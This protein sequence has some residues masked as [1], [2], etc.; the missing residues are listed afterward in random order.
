MAYQVIVPKAVQKQIDA[1]PHRIGVKISEHIAALADDP[2]PR[3]YIKLRGFSNQYRIRIGNY[4]IRYRIDDNKVI[5]F[6]LSA[7]HRK[8]A[9]KD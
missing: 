3:G 7:T 6:V 8:D 5:V 1:L 2:R 4:R 9:Y